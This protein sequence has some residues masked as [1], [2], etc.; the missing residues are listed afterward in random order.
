ML[1]FSASIVAAILCAFGS[2]K[3]IRARPFR[4]LTRIHTRIHVCVSFSEANRPAGHVGRRRDGSRY[5]GR[6]R[7]VPL[8]YR[9]TY[10]R[11]RKLQQHRLLHHHS[12]LGA[13]RAGS[14]RAGGAAKH[15]L[16][17]PF[18]PDHA[19]GRTAARAWQHATPID[20]SIV[21]ARFG[22]RST[23]PTFCRDAASVSLCVVANTAVK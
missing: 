3:S 20:G 19:G 13:G 12:T 21:L 15:Q 7:H 23:T 22:L 17:S 6:G 4:R 18:D 9:H 11:R 5:A 16:E 1:Y 8:E 2:Q 14:F 10:A